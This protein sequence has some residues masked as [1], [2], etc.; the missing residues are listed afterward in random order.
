MYISFGEISSQGLSDSIESNFEI[1]EE[2]DLSRE[3]N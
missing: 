3:G 2:V 1:V